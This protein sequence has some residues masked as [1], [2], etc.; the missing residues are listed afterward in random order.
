MQCLHY[1]LLQHTIWS[2]HAT[3]I[4]I[5]L[6]LYLNIRI[7]RVNKCNNFFSLSPSLAQKLMTYE[8]E[9]VK[10]RMFVNDFGFSFSF[11]ALTEMAWVEKCSHT[12]QTH[13]HTFCIY[14]AWMQCT[15]P[16]MDAFRCHRCR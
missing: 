15:I 7:R 5:S 3:Q 11:S 10:E 4:V 2:L 14:C 6:S 12:T 16:D 8:R 13:T 1:K 9:R